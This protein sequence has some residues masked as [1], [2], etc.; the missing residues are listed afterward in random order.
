MTSNKTFHRRKLLKNNT[1][2]QSKSNVEIFNRI[3]IYLLSELY[4]SFPVPIAIDPDRLG[5]KAIPEELDFDGAAWSVMDIA[6][7]NRSH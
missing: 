1:M 4:D 3:C 6:T 2:E 7:Q 5:L